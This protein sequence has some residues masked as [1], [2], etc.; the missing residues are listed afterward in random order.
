MWPS[1]IIRSVFQRHVAGFEFE[2]CWFHFSARMKNRDT[3]GNG[4]V[5]FATFF[6]PVTV[7]NVKH[8]T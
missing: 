3:A 4:L 6:G 1:G 8:T 7:Y 2:S 5:I